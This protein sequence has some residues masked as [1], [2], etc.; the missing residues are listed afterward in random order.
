MEKTVISRSGQSRL[1][2]LFLGWGMDATPFLNLRKEGYDILALYNY[3]GF[4]ASEA[5]ADLLPLLE[6][7]REIVVVAWSFGVRVAQEFLLEAE[8]K[9][10]ITRTVAVNGTTQHIHDTCGIPSAI[11][12]GTLANLNEVTVKKFRRRMFASGAHF[13]TALPLLTGRDLQSLAAEL[14]WFGSLPPVPGAPV[15]DRAVIGDAD[16]IFPPANQSEGWSGTLTDHF[17]EMPHFPDMQMLLD[18]YVIDKHLVA[19]RFTEAAPTYGPNAPVQRSVAQRLW[20]LAQPFT[21]TLPSTPSILEIGVGDGTLTRLYAPSFPIECITLWDLAPIAPSLLPEGIR[22]EC[23]DAETAITPL[24]SASV[25]LMLSSSTL[26]WFHSPR[27][28]LTELH[29][30]LAPG[31]IAAIAFYGPETFREIASLTGQS[32][33]YPTLDYLRPAL[34]RFTVEFAA[35]EPTQQRFPSLREMMR[36]MQLTGVNALTHSA[37]GQS[38]AMRLMRRFPTAPDGSASLTHHPVYL[39]L[40]K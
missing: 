17:S 36:H 21:A 24:P 20:N 25:N 16:L 39:I 18:R 19:E 38:S 34:E 6:P 22:F 31:G 27:R 26:Q 29:R 14:Q 15:W 1:I 9:V 28:F 32:L 5:V 40:R 7:Y 3:T 30:V 35:E 4:R 13:Q 37:N 33:R 2:L 23:C 8:G 12:A 10:N 11:F